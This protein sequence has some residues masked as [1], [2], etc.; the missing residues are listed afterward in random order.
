MIRFINC[1][2]LRLI[3]CGIGARYDSC[4]HHSSAERYDHESRSGLWRGQ[5]SFSNAELFKSL[6]SRT[7]DAAC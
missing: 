1:C 4:A 5:E 7:P 6:R 3:G 2:R